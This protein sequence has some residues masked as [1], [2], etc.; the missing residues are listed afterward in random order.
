MDPLDS[1]EEFRRTLKP[2]RAVP[3]SETE[4]FKIFNI[5]IWADS[6]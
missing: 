4:P 3:K 1:V 5:L 6:E 2:P